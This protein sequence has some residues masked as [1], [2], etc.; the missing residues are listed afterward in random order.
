[1][2]RR[3]RDA[4]QEEAFDDEPMAMLDLSAYDVPPE[5]RGAFRAAV[6][7]GGDD[8]ADRE[9]AETTHDLPT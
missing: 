2:Q 5:R 8:D 7:A 4:E 9:R 6:A 3:K 1:M